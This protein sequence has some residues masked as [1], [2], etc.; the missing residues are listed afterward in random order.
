MMEEGMLIG[1]P[2]DGLTA[3]LKDGNTHAV[4]SNDNAFQTAARGAF[5]EFYPQGKPQ[6]LEP[7]MNVSVEGPTEYQGEMVGTILQRRGI[8]VGTTEN[9]G[10]VRIEAEV[11]LKEMFGYATAL[12]SV[13]QGK[14]EFTMEFHRYTAAPRDVEEELIKKYQAERAA[15]AAKK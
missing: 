10:T 13:T 11:P 7:M 3:D 1:A 15:E 12:R 9:L 2:I 4:D 6:V 5:R 8:L 14:A